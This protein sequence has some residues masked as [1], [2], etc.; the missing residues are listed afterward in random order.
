MHEGRT[1]RG[2]RSRRLHGRSIQ[3]ERMSAS[4]ENLILL[5]PPE[6]AF[7]SSLP[8]TPTKISILAA[9]EQLIVDQKAPL[10]YQVYTWRIFL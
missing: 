9:P 3:S 8:G 1:E 5:A 4:D 6:G 2:T 10:Y 7:V